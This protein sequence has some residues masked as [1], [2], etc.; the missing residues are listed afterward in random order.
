ML[1]LVA[2]GFQQVK[3]AHVAYRDISMNMIFHTAYDVDFK[4]GC[5]TRSR[6]HRKEVF[7]CL[8]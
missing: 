5:K 8:V 6:Q 7:L 3:L 1:I 4:A 2:Y